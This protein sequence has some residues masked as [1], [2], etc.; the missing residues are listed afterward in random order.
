MHWFRSRSRFGA[1]LALFALAFQLVVSFAHVHRD[2][3]TPLR[4]TI[5]RSAATHVATQLPTQTPAL[6]DGYC[7]VCALIQLAGTVI[8]PQPPALRLPIALD[9]TQLPPHREF[10][11]TAAS[12][13]LFAARAPPIA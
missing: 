13:V 5:H 11:L 2:G 6:A 10:G 1:C 8:A 12:H 9:P 3:N 4:L 7:A